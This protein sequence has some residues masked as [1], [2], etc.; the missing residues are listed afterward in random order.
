MLLFNNLRYAVV[1]AVL[2]LPLSVFAQGVTTASMSGRITDGGTGEE[3]IG[4]NVVAVHVPSGTTY[5]N[6]TDIN[7]FFRLPNMRVGGPYKVTI[8]YTGYETSE[9]AGIYLALGQTYQLNTNLSEAA[10]ELGSVEVVSSRADLFQGSRTGQET[11]IDEQ[12]ITEL[13][14]VSRAIAD[15]VRLN[16]L[17]SL[18]E[19]NDGF[20][21]SLAGQNNRYNTIYI[22][23]AVN[24][25]VFGLA[26]SGTNGGQTGA[27][28]ISIDAIEQFQVAVAPFDVRQSGFAGGAIN[29]ITRSGTNDFEGSAYYFLR[30]ENFT[31]NEAFTNDDGFNFTD[32]PEFTAETY[33]FRLG[34]PI[35]KD[36]LFFFVNGELQ[37]N[38]TPQPFDVANYIGASDQTDLDNLANSIQQQFGYDVG[39][40]DNNTAFLD[41]DFI[42][43]KIDWNVSDA[44]KLSLRHSFNRA[45]NLE[46]RNSDSDDIEFIN[47]SE[48]FVSE[49]NSTALE[50]STIINNNLS[51]NLTIGLTV[52]RDDR[53]PFGPEFPNV[54]L[55]DGEGDITLGAETF[56]TANLLNQDVFTINNDFQI[57]S[58]RH[59]FLIGAN[60]EYFKAGNL[61]I[62]DNFG[63]YVYNNEFDGDNLV[64]TGTERFLAGLPA[65]RYDLSFSQVD[66][67]TGDESS[68]IAEFTSYQFG[69]Y[70]QDE[71]SVTDRTTITFGLRADAQVF[72]DDVPL[73]R[74][75]N[76]ETIPAIESFGYD[77][78]GARTGQTITPRV[79]FSPRV[80][81]NADLTGDRRT[82]L[83][84]G[85]GVFTSRIPLVW[86]GGA[87][88]NYGFNVGGI[89]LRDSIV[90]EPNVNN[91]PGRPEDLNNV[92]PS[93]Q[94]DLFTPNF[95][96]PQVLKLN[97]ALD[98]RIQERF[99]LTVEGLFT[100]TLS[101]VRYQNFNLKPAIGT[102]QGTPDNRPVFDQFDQV[103]D[104][105]TGI[106]LGSNTNRGYAFNAAATFGLLRT[107]G[108]SGSVS[109]S[110]G[111]SY[112]LYDGT[113]SQNSSQWQFFVNTEGKNE[114]RRP[115][116][117]SFAQGHR[118]IGQF[119]YEVEYAG[120]MRSQLSL[121]LDA[122][123]S[124]PFSYTVRA[125]NQDFINDGGRG[126]EPFFVPASE[127]DINLVEA[128]IGGQTFSAAEQYRILDEFIE[129]DPYLS[130]RRGQYADPNARFGP[131]ETALDLRFLQDFYIETANGKR[132]T[133]QLSIDIFNF[134]N[135][136]NQDWGKQYDTRFA[137]FSPVN[138]SNEISADNLVPQ[139]TINSQIVDMD[140]EDIFNNDLD[141]E[142]FRSSIWNMQVG[143]RY[144]FQ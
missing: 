29:A 28:P 127:D 134:A 57:F 42:I 116:R 136:L 51:N 129:A 38:E 90:F 95:R 104:N 60:F 131:F 24:N 109:Y 103:D 86:I 46:A 115:F 14:T 18:D 7:G 107:N 79:Y 8:S 139:Y 106:Y 26:S 75:F 83:R 13:P 84:G 89:R 10:I 130:E 94:I 70:L 126:G 6:S 117:S 77:L 25:D 98:Q 16:P 118:V 108:F 113:S 20:S 93:G 133:L 27:S 34:G 37:R 31:R 58:G 82:Q 80:G 56:S 44:T 99:F 33:G 67:L 32:V 39:T 52:V 11:V 50:I 87:Y 92:T 122:G 12:V 141:T 81:F 144:I 5:G 74:Q 112:V 143:L 15:F 121:F 61:F 17:A 124:D 76:T 22:D 72:P 111:D 142:G 21:I 110:Y 65:D 140:P 73:N 96:V 114:T 54:N 68:A 3:L 35:V 36:K 69:L 63:E 41:T 132:N 45:E 78:Q 91:Q 55:Q 97:L 1:V 66:N 88:N 138:L 59:N 125:S 62:R 137:T 123:T 101:G 135:L 53:D 128:T 23:G 48:F 49:T 102:L 64:M 85:I 119:S 105:Y 19:G 100:Q 43:G 30:N 47:G 4:A 120:F 2:C 40:F 9:D 71:W